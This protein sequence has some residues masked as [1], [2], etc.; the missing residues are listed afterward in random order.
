[1]HHRLAISPP[2]AALLLALAVLLSP[3][4]APAMRASESPASSPLALGAPFPDVTIQGDLHGNQADYLGVDPMPGRFALLGL[5]ARVVILEI[6]SMYCPFCQE[7]APETRRLYSLI[8]KRGLAEDIKLMGL[9]AGNSQM[10]VDIFRNKYGIEFP[11]FPDPEFKI[12]NACGQVGTPF[13]YILEKDPNVGG[14]VIRLTH[15]GR[16]DSPEA[17]L[18]SVL[19]HTGL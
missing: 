6:Y 10:E 16:M 15:L 9:A 3:A 14:F 2:A 18:E 1:M 5:K 13:F 12:H 17:L 7:E 4:D 11:L 19:E 8:A